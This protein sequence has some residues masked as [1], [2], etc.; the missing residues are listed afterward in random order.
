VNDEPDAD[1]REQGESRVDLYLLRHAD[2]GDPY[3]WKGEDAA[4]PL[5]GKGRRQAERL[6]AH[7]AGIG[8]RVDVIL[9][10]PK[11]RAHETARLVGEA[12]GAKPE[13]DDRLADALEIGL[14][15]EMLGGRD[16]VE[17]LMLVGHDP[18]FSEL[19]AELIGID[20]LPMRKGALAGLDAALPLA[21]GS[22][23]LRWLLPPDAIKPA[24][25][26]PG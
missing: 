23:V 2:A 3:A 6:G 4:R 21:P 22:A 15:Q 13:L 12:I 1:S 19:L 10:S 5:S 26:K 8:F 18:D 9:S 14:V 25:A 11:L 17:S 20:E 7:L 16:P 24:K